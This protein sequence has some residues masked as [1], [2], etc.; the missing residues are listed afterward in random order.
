MIAE[1]VHHIDIAADALDP[2]PDERVPQK[3]Q[4]RA[5]DTIPLHAP[6]LHADR[7]VKVDEPLKLNNNRKAPVRPASDRRGG[8]SGWVGLLRLA[9]G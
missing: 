1:R 5:P 9:A 8:W 6:R 3:R 2:M 4:L 7:P